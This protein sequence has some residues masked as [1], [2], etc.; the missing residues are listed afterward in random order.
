MK[1]II[2]ISFLG[3]FLASGWAAATS[4][5]KDSM[6]NTMILK[7]TTLSLQCSSQPVILE[8]AESV[9]IKIK[10][11]TSQLIEPNKPVLPIIVKTY[12]VPYG[13]KNIKVTCTPKDINTLVLSKKIMAACIAP[14]SKISGITTNTK[15]DSIYNSTLFYPKSWY[16]YTIGAGCDTNGD[17]IIFIKIVCYPV[18]YSP[19]NNQIEYTTSFDIQVTYE[20]P[21]TTAQTNET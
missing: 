7:N 19:A 20:E 13:S 15:D 16:R 11:M 5:P 17:E 14:L 18:R 9:V 8:L 3:F 2:A 6:E 12:Q 21:L 10:E 4:E 1:K